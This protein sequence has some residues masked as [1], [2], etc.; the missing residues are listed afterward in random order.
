[1]GADSDRK[2][3]DRAPLV[4]AQ[5]RQIALDLGAGD[6]AACL[7]QAEGQAARQAGQAAVVERLTQAAQVAKG[8]PGLGRQP[9][10]DAP[11]GPLARRDRAEIAQQPHARRKGIVVE[12]TGRQG[13]LPQHVAAA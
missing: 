5:R 1:M 8:A 11:L 4:L 9:G 2:G 3:L 10:L 6:D 7:D 13:A 12:D